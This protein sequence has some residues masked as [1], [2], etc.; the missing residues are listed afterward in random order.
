[1]GNENIF[2]RLF[3]K[4]SRRIA[5]RSSRR[6]VLARLGTV[7]VGAAV[8][9][10]LPVDRSGRFKRAHAQTFADQAQTADDTQCNYWRYCAMDGYLCSC[11]NGGVTSCPPGSDPSPTSWVG[12]CLNPDDGQVYLIAYRDCCGK[13][14]CGQCPCL[15]TEGEMPVYRPQLSNDID[16]C[17]G[18]SSMV[19]HCTGAGIVGKA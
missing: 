19:Y 14:V 12:S 9:P 4:A 10:T 16:W 5:Q 2:D 17:F 18:A 8:L 1:M 7:L 3:E 6:S 11:C 15:S 13:G